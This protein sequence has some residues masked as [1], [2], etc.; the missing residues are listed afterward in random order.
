M[1]PV[2]SNSFD[3]VGFFQQSF[4]N[5]VEFFLEDDLGS[6]CF[7]GGGFTAF[8]QLFDECLVGIVDRF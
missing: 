5:F 4:L 8:F 7:P 3:F 2:V 1:V 6:F